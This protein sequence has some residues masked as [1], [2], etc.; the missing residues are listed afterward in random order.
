MWAGRLGKSSENMANHLNFDK[1]VSVIHHLVEGN[2]IRATE[3]LTDVHRDTI[4]RLLVRVG[5]Q[6]AAILDDMINDVAADSIECDEIWSYV[7]KKQKRCTKEEK[8]TGERG[9]QYVFVGLDSD[10]KLVISHL[11]GKRSAE[12]TTAFIKDLGSRLSNDADYKPQISSDGFVPYIEAIERQFGDDVDYAQVMKDYVF[13]HAGRGRYSPPKVSGVSKFTIKG[14]PDE[15]DIGTSYVERQ[16]LTMRMSMRRF[17]RLTNAFSKKLLRN[18]KAAVALHFA[19]YNLCRPHSSLRGSTP[20]VA[21]G[22]ATEAWG[23][24][25]DDLLIGEQVAAEQ[26]QAAA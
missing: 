22:L 4:C 11:V 17:T 13:T 2:S 14:Q 26:P 3:R 1:K 9:D 24:L 6:C 7:G 19:Y 12:T 20:A 18:L 23:P 15:G 21:A 25:A 8:K 5:E 10:T 16:N